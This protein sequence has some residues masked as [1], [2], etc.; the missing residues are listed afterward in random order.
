[1]KRCVLTIL[2]FLLAGA[3]VNIAVA[4]IFALLPRDEYWTPMLRG[5]TSTDSG[6]ALKAYEEFGFRWVEGGKKG[7]ST[8]F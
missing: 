3:V 6:W 4:W 2:L 8:F 7:M 1:M 5:V